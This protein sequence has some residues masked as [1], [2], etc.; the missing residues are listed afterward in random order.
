VAARTTLDAHPA[1]KRCL[2]HYGTKC[3]VCGF[4]FEAVY[5]ELGKRFIHVHHLTPPF[6]CTPGPTGCSRACGAVR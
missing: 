3:T 2:E 1:R 6:T 5:G 4:N